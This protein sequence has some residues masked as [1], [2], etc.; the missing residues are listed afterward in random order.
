MTEE[1]GK[2]EETVNIWNVFKVKRS[3][4]KGKRKKKDWIKEKLM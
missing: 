3:R 2:T 4:A 1:R